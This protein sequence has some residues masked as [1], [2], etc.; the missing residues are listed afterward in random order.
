R[1]DIYSFLQESS[2][3]YSNRSGRFSSSYVEPLHKNG[4]LEFKYQLDFNSIGSSRDIWDVEQSMLID[5][6][7]L[8]YKYRFNSHRY[9]LTYKGV[10]ANKFMYTLGLALQPITL[11][12]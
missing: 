10:M 6:L 12:G 4:D 8:D 2:N 1:I 7:G 9:G 3:L 5:S 11:E